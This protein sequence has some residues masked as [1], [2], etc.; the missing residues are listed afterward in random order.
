M[1]FKPNLVEIEFSRLLPVD[2]IPAAGLTQTHEA[3]DIERQALAK[4]FGL[5]DIASLRG[6]MTVGPLRSDQTIQV[7]GKITADVTQQC[8]VTLEPLP[9]HIEQD[10]TVIFAADASEAGLGNHETFGTEEIEPI[11][12]GAIDLGELIAQHLGISLD[13]YPRKPG[14]AFI[15]ASYGDVGAKAGPMAELLKLTKKPKDSK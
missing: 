7:T 5:L 4:R 9:A 10:I 13:P 14:Q 3:K 6:D 1:K 12:D 15:E 2:K 8:V 11:V